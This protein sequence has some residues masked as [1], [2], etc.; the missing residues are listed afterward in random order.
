MIETEQ[1]KNFGHGWISGALSVM[2]GAIGVGAVLCFHFPWILTMP[3]LREMYPVPYIRALLHL[4][5]VSS[6]VLG[7]VSMILRETK[8][9]GLTGIGLT[10]LA[11][12]MGGSQVPI[13]GEMTN[14]PFLGL[15]WFLLNLIFFSALFIPLE[16]WFPK[17]AQQPILRLSWRTDLTYFFVGAVLIQLISILTLRPAMIL[18]SWAVNAQIQT[19]VAGLPYVV[20]FLGVLLV[21]DF[22]QYWVHRSFHVVPMLWRFHAVH[23]S[24]ESMDWLAGSRLHLVDI[25]LTRGISY[26]PIYLLGFAEGPIFAYIVFVSVQATFIHSNLRFEFGPLRWLMA[27]PQFHHWHHC[28]DE[29]HLDKN[30]AVHLPFL[31]R[32]FGTYYLP[33]GVWPSSYGVTG[34]TTSSKGY[35]G[36]LAEPFLPANSTKSAS[37]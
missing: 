9:A 14:G 13:D 21:A 18:F 25:A 15:D 24:A 30:F 37:G 28:S 2:L 4:I 27:T 6:F 7:A 36:Q 23:H 19:W 20:Q 33:K 22:T 17:R 34:T 26:V 10:L 11:A 5:L 31:D 32:L 35:V 1:P 29:D 3:E 8:V 12:L 16:Q